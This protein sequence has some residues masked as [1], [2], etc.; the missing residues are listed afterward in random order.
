MPAEND[1]RDGTRNS[2]RQVIGRRKMVVEGYGVEAGNHNTEL[3][4][5][6]G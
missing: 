1:E 4:K 5:E 2:L 6:D 3:G